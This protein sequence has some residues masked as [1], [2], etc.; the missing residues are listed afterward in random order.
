MQYHRI[1]ALGGTFFFTL[2]TYERRMIV[3]FRCAQPN[4]RAL[5]E[6]IWMTR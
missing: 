1:N 3:G 5:K 2:V 4:L 6:R